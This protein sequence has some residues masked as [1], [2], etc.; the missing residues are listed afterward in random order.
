MKVALT[1]CPGWTRIKPPLSLALLA[2]VLHA[3]NY[4]AHA[5]DL[6]NLLYHAS[7]EEYKAQWEQENEFYWT[8]PA[9]VSKFIRDHKQVIDTHVNLIL[10]LESPL[11]GF[12]VYYPNQLMTIE[13]ARL[14]KEKDRSKIIVCG[15]PQC[16]PELG[17]IELLRHK[18]IDAIALYEG[19]R[20]IVALANMVEERKKIDYCKG[21]VFKKDGSLV[22]CGPQEAILNIDSLPFADFS[23]FT[24]QKYANQNELPLLASRGCFWNCAFCVGKLNWQGYRS[25]SGERVFKEVVHQLQKYP[26]VNF[27]S[28]HDCLINGNISMLERFCELVIDHRKNGYMKPI[29][30]WCQAVI[31]PEM[32]TV[33][34]EKMKEAGCQRISYG[35]ESGSQ[36]VIDL[37]GK[38]FIIS[39]ASE[40]IRNT[41]KSGIKVVTN[42]MFG[43]PGE[44]EDD[45]EQ[46]LEFI[47][48]NKDHID[49][50]LPVEGLCVIER[51]SRLYKEAKHYGLYS[52]PHPHYWKTKD[53]KNTYLERFRRFEALVSKASASRIF[54]TGAYKKNIDSK[55]IFL[56]D[57][58]NYCSSIAFNICNGL[59]QKSTGQEYAFIW[60]ITS[61]CNFACPY[62]QAI[63]DY[64]SSSPLKL[65]PR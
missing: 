17:G 28:F 63:N 54:L 24:L 49:E 8:N 33:L 60:E 35:I 12:S 31:R 41:H 21:I 44:E 51:D 52:N 40:V 53:G 39:V 34:L 2:P 59:I 36:K 15:G 4:D 13:I 46:T 42:F 45:F 56:S 9:F 38:Q 55:K 5:I 7:R 10:D 25:Q 43:F 6:N 58:N 23:Y 14:I 11:I 65:L 3:Q 16:M 32:T 57:Y 1:I 62:C 27:F 30:W 47:E 64:P 29:Q 19:E 22:N 26:E 18:W 61:Q 37:M 50:L 20:T 48:R